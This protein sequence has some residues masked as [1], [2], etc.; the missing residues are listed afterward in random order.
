MVDAVL[1]GEDA[2]SSFVLPLS[3]PQIV[4]KSGIQRTRSVRR[5]VHEVLLHVLRSVRPPRPLALAR[6]LGVTH[7]TYT[8]SS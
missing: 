4:C 7:T 6:G 1:R 2:L 3:V 8:T 5:D